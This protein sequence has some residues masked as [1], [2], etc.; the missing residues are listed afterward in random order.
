M[1]Y[2]VGNHGGGPTK[3]NLDSIRRL[4]RDRRAAPAAA[5]ARRGRSS[6]GRRRAGATIP[7][8]AGELQ[9]HAVGC[10]S[11][12]S[13]VKRWNRRAENLLARAEKWA[14]VADGARR[15]APTR[16]PTSSE[17]WKLVL[18]NQFHD[19][20]AARPIEPAYEDSRDQFGH[21][22][23]LAGEA[24]NRVGAVTIAADRHRAGDRT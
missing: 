3:A 23:S 12:H 19:T 10:Y 24:F 18:F 5:A 4:D 9:H 7:V 13:G 6:T 1:F 21:A 14:S 17:A 2:G 15:R 16:S 8:H 20:L 11:A 22:V